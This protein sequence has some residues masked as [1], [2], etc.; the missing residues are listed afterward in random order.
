M[1]HSS[2]K[3]CGGGQ[4]P[5]S[6]GGRQALLCALSTFN[7]GA[8]IANPSHFCFPFQP[9]PFPFLA[10]GAGLS[11]FAEICSLARLLSFSFHHLPSVAAK[12][13]SSLQREQVIFFFTEA[14]DLGFACTLIMVA[15][16][17]LLSWVHFRISA[18]SP[19]SASSMGGL[20]KT[21]QCGSEVG[22]LCIARKGPD[23]GG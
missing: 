22:C 21:G 17:L 4:G 6:S 14:A 5:S 7:T 1:P 9:H 19:C 12:L 2:V 3:W 23:R 20:E 13:L 11:P 16:A 10:G 15:L 8:G 18:G